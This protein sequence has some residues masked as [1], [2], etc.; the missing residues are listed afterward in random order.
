MG[1]IFVA[2]LQQKG[3]LTT[4]HKVMIHVTV[5]AQLSLLPYLKAASYLLLA[6]PINSPIWKTSVQPQ[7]IFVPMRV[8]VWC[9]LAR[10][11]FIELHTFESVEA[12]L[13]PM[14]LIRMC[15]IG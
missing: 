1:Y 12:K 5:G 3:R 4:L 11:V 8:R 10:W 2:S 14:Y 6:K 15:L 13:C 9:S 7:G